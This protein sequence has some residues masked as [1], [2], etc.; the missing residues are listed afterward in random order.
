MY[1][2]IN[3]QGTY[4]SSCGRHKNTTSRCKNKHLIKIQSKKK[5]TKKTNLTKQKNK[6]TNDNDNKWSLVKMGTKNKQTTRN[7]DKNNKY[8]H[9]KNIWYNSKT[10]A[11]PL[12]ISEYSFCYINK[13]R[14]FLINDLI[15]I[16][17]SKT[18]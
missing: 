7:N 17:W 12:K 9:H 1:L 8:P 2:F 3:Y 16:L 6:T 11:T 15:V 18:T 14:T 10:T 4:Y 13:P 5:G